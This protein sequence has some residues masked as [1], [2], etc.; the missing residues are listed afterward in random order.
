MVQPLVAIAGGNALLAT[1]CVAFTLAASGVAIVSALFKGKRNGE[2]GERK[3][4]PTP[5]LAV[6]SLLVR[7]TRHSCTLWL[8]HRELM[9]MVVRQ[10]HVIRRP[11]AKALNNHRAHPLV[12]IG[13]QQLASARSAR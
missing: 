1:A 10:G 5:Q 11:S 4:L 13:H 8:L 3:S 9:F 12:P 7:K 2:R 6:A